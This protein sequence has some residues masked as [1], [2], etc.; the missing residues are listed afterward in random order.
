MRAC[1]S[2]L[3]FCALTSAFALISSFYVLGAP[4][5]SR[6]HKE[7]SPRTDPGSSRPSS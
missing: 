6:L 1:V 7:Q 3:A 4:I 5:D 2:P